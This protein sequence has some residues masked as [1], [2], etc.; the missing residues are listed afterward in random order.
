MK[1][2]ILGT[3]NVGCAMACDLSK[4]GHT[5]TLI[6]TSQSVHNDSFAYIK[7]N[8]NAI[9]MFE[10][11]GTIVEANIDTLTTDVSCVSSA[12]IVMVTVQTNY[13]EELIKRISPW[14][15]A[16]QI[17]L[18]IPGYLS[19]AYMLKHCS[20][21]DIIIVEAESSFIDCRLK[22]LNTINVSFRNVRNPLG[23]FPSRR[24][25]KVEEVLKQLDFPFVFLSSVIEA[26]LHN[27]NLIVHTVGAIMSIPRVEKTEGNYYMYHEVFTPSV[28]NILENLDG[29]KMNI[30]EKLGFERLSYVQACK[31]RNSLDANKDAKTVFFEYA[32]DPNS[33]KGPTSVDSRYITEDVSQGLVLL[34]TL[35]Y[36]LNICTPLATSL[37]EIAS[38]ALNR[39]LRKCGRNVNNLGMHN[40]NAL[41]KD[42]GKEQINNYY[43]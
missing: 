21:K 28:W 23:V 10:T 31:Y 42:N 32:N 7:S 34:E 22:D 38:A 6:K 36:S 5:I 40:I 1:V 14:I 26:A 43:E 39:D 18:F 3:G 16:N 2:A 37:I 20:R 8:N 17:I 29:E 9:R 41:L 25:A 35:G 13:H 30:L 24:K 15:K 4:K 27:P 19:T 33:V 11:D 12:E